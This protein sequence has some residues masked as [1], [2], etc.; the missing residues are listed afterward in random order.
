MCVLV[1]LCFSSCWLSV[2]YAQTRLNQADLV[3]LRE[4]SDR[5]SPTF[6]VELVSAIERLDAADS[7]ELITELIFLFGELRYSYGL[8]TSALPAVEAAHVLATTTGDASMAA[9]LD[10]LA[11]QM[12]FASNRTSNAARDR[13]T[14]A[15][16]AQRSTGRVL[17]LARQLSAYATLLQDISEF[18]YAMRMSNEAV[19]LVEGDSSAKSGVISSVALGVYYTNAELLRAVGDTKAALAAAEKLLKLSLQAGNQEFAGAADLAMGRVFTRAGQLDR[20]ATSLESSYARAVLFSDPMGLTVAAL[21]RA[22]IA[23]ERSQFAVATDWS[24]KVAPVIAQI[25]DPVLRARFS[26]QQARLLAIAGH[27]KLARLSLDRA[28]IAATHDEQ[29]WLK[30]LI[31]TAEG[32]VLASE[33]QAMASLQAMREAAQLNTESDRLTMRDVVA[34]Q[35]D[36]YRLNERELREKQT[37]QESRL[38]DLQLEAAEQRLLTQRLTVAVVA[39]LAFAA[40]AIAAW[41][42][43]RARSFRRRADTDSLTGALSRAAVA[44]VGSGAFQR[45]QREGGAVSLLLLDVDGLKAVNDRDGHAQG[46]RLLVL[47]A[48][49][50]ASGL[51]TDDCVGRWGGDEFVVVMD[52]ADADTAKI[53]AGRLRELIEQGL[54]L[55]GFMAATC[56]VGVV[57]VTDSDESFSRALAR[58]DA[59]MYQA[60]EGGKNQVVIA[61]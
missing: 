46:D 24:N 59:A 19:S 57:T 17:P 41:Q 38:R 21:E 56:S 25:D 18:A 2:S 27:A 13:I 39:L 8:S 51:R 23:M 49:L 45:M 30:A 37:A 33:G 32:E 58:A 4:L 11:G 55:S 15:L 44:S 5:G 26:L 40:A 14:R 7:P 10:A 48:S 28:K 47:A 54:K 43:V 36:L 34:A 9:S 6:N 31:R 1:C 60:K 22:D 52:R 42:I 61:D 12:E 3:R 50:I 20:A 29:L 35:G 16:K 53:V